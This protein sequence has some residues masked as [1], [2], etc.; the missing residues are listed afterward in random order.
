MSELHGNYSDT[1]KP[2]AKILNVND[3]L[4]ASRRLKL[5]NHEQLEA[6]LI[7][8]AEA[9]RQA[10]ADRLGLSGATSS[11]EL[12]LEGLAA[13]FVAGKSNEWPRVLADLDPEGELESPED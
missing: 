9:L 13:A 11:A 12:E 5:P 10:L 4:E 2:M 8:A 3:M 1:Q 7:T 6:D